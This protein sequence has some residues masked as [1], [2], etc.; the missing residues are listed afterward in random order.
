MLFRC[1]RRS[2]EKFCETVDGAIDIRDTVHLKEGSDIVDFGRTFC[3]VIDPHG[4]E[5]EREHV[6]GGWNAN[7]QPDIARRSPREGT[8]NIVIALAC[9][10]AQ[11]KPNGIIE[12][13][14]SPVARLRNVVHGGFKPFRLRH[15]DFSDINVFGGESEIA[16]Q[17]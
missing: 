1:C 4:F 6:F 13:V 8:E 12:P 15:S 7:G 2:W 10:I 11:V 17:H 3:R 9:K 5:L 14:W 16:R